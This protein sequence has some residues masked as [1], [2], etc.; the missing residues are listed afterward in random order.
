MFQVRIL[1]FYL[2]FTVNLIYPSTYYIDN[3]AGNDKNSG[4]SASS[5]WK[6]IHKINIYSF[7]QGDIVSFKTNSRFIL[8]EPLTTKN[9]LTFNSYGKGSRP[10]IDGGNAHFCV[11]FDGAKN[12]KFYNLKFVNGKPSNLNLWNCS[13][14]LVES[15]NVDSSKGANIHNCNIYS[16]EGSYLTVRKSTLNYSQQGLHEGNLGIY[17]DGT[18]NCLL[19][20]DTILGNFSNIRI[21]FGN[22]PK[23]DYTDNLIVRYCVVKYGKYDNIDD[24]GSRNAQFYYNIFETDATPGYHDNVYI[25]SDGSGKFDRYSA[26]G[27]KYYNNTFISYSKGCTFEVRSG[28][29]ATNIILANNIFYNT[30]PSGWMFYSDNTFGKWT[31]NNNLYYTTAKDYDHY[32]RINSRTING[33]GMWKAMVKDVNS[34]CA[35]P[36]FNNFNAGDYT[37]QKGSPAIKAG[38]NVGL[39]TDNKGSAVLSNQPDIGAMQYNSK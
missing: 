5:A 30:D 19:E 16:G 14:I 26:I 33:F 29:V 20:Y 12:V 38:I 4:L 2:L 35:N 37:L 8:T 7:K 11:N 34:I 9:N 36:L 17:I 18:E 25:F 3:V 1:L 13:H 31:F 23:Y 6:T 15:C 21:G 39:K 24:D 27:S 32:W 28:V 10:I 22:A